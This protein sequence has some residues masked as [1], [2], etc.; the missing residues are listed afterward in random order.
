MALA[1]LRHRFPSPAEALGEPFAAFP[2]WFLRIT[3]DRRGKDRMGNEAYAPWRDKTLREKA[4][5]AGTNSDREVPYLS[6]SFDGRGTGVGEMV[7]SGSRAAR[8]IRSNCHKA[9]FMD[10]MLSYV[11]GRGP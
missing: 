1:E 6:A 10:E 8:I 3:C 2:S 9:V 4:E 11:P 7:A 5:A